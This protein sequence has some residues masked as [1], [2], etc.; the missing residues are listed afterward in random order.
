M[1]RLAVTLPATDQFVLNGGIAL[2]PDGSDLVYVANR[3]GVQQLHRRSMDELEPIPIDGTEGGESPFF[4]PDGESVGFIANSTL[5]KV[6]LAGGPSVALCNV[7]GWGASWGQDDVIVFG[8][9]AGLMRVSASGGTPELITTL[10][11]GEIRHQFPEFLPGGQAVLFSVYSGTPGTAQIAVHSLETGKRQMIE[12]G[13]FMRYAPTGHIVFSRANSLWAVPFDSDRLAATGAATPV[14]AGVPPVNPAGLTNFALAGDGALA[15]VP[16]STLGSS[17][18]VWVDREGREELVAADPQNYREFTLSPNGTQIAVRIVGS[19]DEDLWIHDLLLDTW[20]RLT[21]D[22]ASERF[23]LWT[24]DGERVAFGGGQGMFW[25]FADGTGDVEPI[26]ETPSHQ[27]PLAFSPDGSV[28]VF[29]DLSEGMDLGM[30]SLEGE[31]ASTPLLNTNAVEAN[32]TISPDGCRIAYQSSESGQFEIYVRPFPDVDDGKWQVSS[33]GGRWPLWAPDGRELFY[34]QQDM[35]MMAVSVETEPTFTIGKREPLFGMEPYFV[36]AIVRRV[37]ISPDGQRFLLLK[38][39]TGSQDAA[40]PPSII[41]VLNW[42]EEL[43]RLVP[44][45]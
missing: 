32:A 26:V 41:V 44:T 28:L 35:E 38:I 37:A 17:R 30:V 29:L 24:P 27:R 14:L 40:V 5:Q 42:F 12:S 9:S 2:S 43:K 22:P 39:G 45:N 3:D 25:K 16:G 10:G 4:S 34:L 36:Q 1:T 33:D 20:T 31:R 21:F 19:I 7:E 8:S 15:Y 13:N 23:P 6:S 18:F 11:A